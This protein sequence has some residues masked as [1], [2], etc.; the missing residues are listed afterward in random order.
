MMQTINI[1]KENI[2]IYKLP[3]RVIFLHM[4]IIVMSNFFAINT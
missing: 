2:I 1:N 4:N 3:I